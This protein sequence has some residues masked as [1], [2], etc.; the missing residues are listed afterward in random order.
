MRAQLL[1]L[2]ASTAGTE[3]LRQQLAG[4]LGLVQ[5]LQAANVALTKQLQDRSNG[6]EAALAES[7]RARQELSSQLAQAQ[8][9]LAQLQQQH[10]QVE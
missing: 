5:E 4:Q 3:A 9:T 2:Q 6:A 1:E 8:H 10:R 7:Q